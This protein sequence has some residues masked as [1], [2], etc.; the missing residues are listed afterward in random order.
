[1]WRQGRLVWRAGVLAITLLGCSHS[2]TQSSV[3]TIKVAYWGGPEEIAIT[4]ELVAD[5]ER[6]HPQVKVRLEHTPFSA[7]T[8]RLLT[9]MAGNVAPDIMA[10]EVNLFPTLWSKDVFLSL[11]P[12]LEHDT[13][14]A[15]TDFFPDVIKRFTVDG[16]VYAIPRDTAPFACIYYNK[17]LFDDAGLKYPSDEWTT[18]DLL[19]AAQRLTKTQEGRIAQYGF[20]AWAWQN[21]V[22]SNGGRLVDDLR[23]PTRCLL[24]EPQAIEGLQFYADLMN[25][26]KVAPT[27]IALGNLAMGAQQLF[28]TQRV[29]MFSSGFWEVPIL[30]QIKDFDWDV[31]MF[32]K[33][34]HGQRA[35]ATGGTG[36]CI[37]K[38]SQHPQEAWEVLKALAGPTAQERLAKT[39]L[40]QPALKNVAEGEAFARNALP[41]LNK[42]MMNEAVKYEVY[43]PFIAEWRELFDR[44]IGPE[45]DL[46]FNG[47]KTAKDA[48]DAAVPQVNAA[49]AQRRAD[50][51]ERAR[52]AVTSGRSSG[53]SQ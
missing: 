50:E 26:Y 27:P 21:F 13:E 45:L 20:Y 41:P 47:Q 28:M 16:N 24:G 25:K 15:S 51:V 39:G 7:Y 12:F 23:N 33:G 14:V 36:Y 6:A 38:S 5:W 53:K 30:R 40:T 32:P 52:A 9:R 3:T 19:R 48:M 10:V 42:G 1:M 29:A 17:R 44:Y 11:Q 2:P 31:V 46:V 22:Y 34:G 8:S 35:F 4:Q 43:E 49:L 18:Q 37:L